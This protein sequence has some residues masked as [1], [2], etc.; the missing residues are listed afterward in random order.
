[1]IKKKDE[2]RAFLA[3]ICWGIVLIS[4]SYSKSL[5]SKGI[6]IIIIY[7]K[8]KH[9]RVQSIF[10]E[11]KIWGNKQHAQVQQIAMIK[12]FN[13]GIFLN[14]ILLKKFIR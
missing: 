1:M 2:K 7:K 10:F 9:A 13:P 8:I 5:I 6:V 4:S 11:Y 14:F 3:P 12:I